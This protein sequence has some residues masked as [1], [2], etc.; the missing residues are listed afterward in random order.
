[1]IMVC[2]IF[3]RSV[4]QFRRKGRPHQ[5]AEG[6]FVVTQS[7]NCRAAPPSERLLLCE[8]SQFSSVTFEEQSSQSANYDFLPGSLSRRVP[9]RPRSLFLSLSPSHGAPLAAR[10]AAVPLPPPRATEEERDGTSERGERNGRER[11]E[12]RGGHGRCAGVTRVTRTR[13][14]LF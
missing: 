11:K 14:C 2:L 13:T 8:F 7:A 6:L 5:G 9:C 12:E 10:S 1:M 3:L 4:R